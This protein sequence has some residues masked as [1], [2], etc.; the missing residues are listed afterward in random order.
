MRNETTFD[1]AYGTR[2]KIFRYL[3]TI[4]DFAQ[5]PNTSIS[6]FT[7]LM[8]LSFSLGKKSYLEKALRDPRCAVE[9]QDANASTFSMAS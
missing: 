3:T 5:W 8:D 1:R 6:R 7:I 2:C 9:A 4:Y